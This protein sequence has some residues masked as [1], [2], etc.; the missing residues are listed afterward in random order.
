MS[1]T[2]FFA[3]QSDIDDKYCKGFI[4]SAAQ[5]AI[6]RLM[7]NGKK[8]IFDYGFRGTPGT[9]ILIEEMLAKS[10]N[11]DMVL[12][13][14]TYTS[15]KNWFYTKEY[16]KFSGKNLKV[17]SIKNDKKSS[18]PNVLLETGYAWA[19]KGYHRTLA[20]MNTA[21]GKPD[22]LNVDFQG[23]RWPITYH[24]DNKN[25]NTR[26][27][28]RKSLSDALYQAI[29][30]SINSETSYQ[31][32]KWKP[33]RVNQ[34][35][36]N[37]AFK[38]PYKV[39]NELKDIILKLRAGL[40][41]NN[42]PQR[43]VGPAKSGKTRLARE[44]FHEYGND[45]PALEIV[46]NVLY[47]DLEETGFASVE[48]P[49]L[50]LTS[51]NQ[52]KVVILDNCSL[53]LHRKLCEDF[54]DTELRLLTIAESSEDKSIDGA[55]VRI[56]SELAKK[57]A[58][59]AVSEKY[60]KDEATK[61]AEETQGNLG[62]ALLYFKSALGKGTTSDLGYEEKWRQILGKFYEEKALE[63][64][65]FISVFKYVGYLAEH[66]SQ[67]DFL[68]K[69]LGIEEQS[70]KLLIEYFLE[71]GI[72][73]I[74]GS[75]LRMIVFSDELTLSWWKKQS[76]E[77]LSDF[78]IK[79]ADMG[80]SRPFGIRLT[81]LAEQDQ[82]RDLI[83]TEGGIFTYENLN[84][85]E[86]SKLV[87]HLAEVIPEI[88]MANLKKIFDGKSSADLLDFKDG[89]RN[90]VWALERLC[91][92]SETFEDATELLYR[93]AIAENES[94]ANNATGQF[95]QLFQTFLAGT[96]VNLERRL[97]LLVSL[98]KFNDDEK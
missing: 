35:W 45:L 66:E 85:V 5:M 87:I 46:E 70:F 39:N 28:V 73:E 94:Y 60:S 72:L 58:E 49:I 76:S 81:E 10:Q 20:V 4:Q 86:G 23:F 61:L 98:F 75:F 25:Y 95:L 38:N 26:K 69:E 77:Y 59:D 19:H 8:V 93:L 47:Y 29:S 89:R 37:S 68:R 52:L 1:Y 22:E 36:T 34:N 56:T 17:K 65:E 27:D 42:N 43:I 54:E 83:P 12:V 30:A 16:V 6:D 24:L 97:K 7:K 84:T 41:V 63:V 71:I 40:A 15:S 79:I 11:S 91:F 78:F 90:L 33:F 48:N 64:L 18:N 21:F 74:K 80:L 82:L 3:Y 92:R 50:S 57:I 32:E 13:D 53:K 67:V 2:V 62:E 51:L 44:M 31:Q 96:E 88:V 14:L 9:P 55:T